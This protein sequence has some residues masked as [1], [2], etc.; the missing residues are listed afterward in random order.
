MGRSMKEIAEKL[1]ELTRRARE[2]TL[3][4]KEVIIIMSGKGGVGKSIVT[5][6]LALALAENDRNVAILD[7]DFHGPSIPWLLGVEEER[8]MAD[9][10]GRIYPVKAGNVKVVSA[11]LALDKK[12]LP[13]IWRGPLKTRAVL[14]LLALVKWGNLDYLLVDLPPG[15]GDEAQTVVRYLKHI[16]LKA[17]LVM[18]PG[19]MVRHIVKKSRNFARMMGVEILGGIVNMAYFRCPHCGK[20]TN[21]FGYERLENIE[22]IAELPL[23]GTVAELANKGK[24]RELFLKEEYRRL[25][26]VS[27]IREACKKISGEGVGQE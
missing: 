2:S 16:P 20:T 12:E 18:I 22:I 27:K 19:R 6:G 23:D 7:A 5:S 15:M 4:I 11:E 14:D 13:I 10:E 17:V 9:E 24:L 3:G 21:V 25:E 1:Q 8:M 26:W